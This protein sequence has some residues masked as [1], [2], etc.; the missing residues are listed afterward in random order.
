M[1]GCVEVSEAEAELE[2]ARRSLLVL[3]SVSTLPRKFKAMARAVG[4]AACVTSYEAATLRV[5]HRR[6]KARQRAVDAYRL[7]LYKEGQERLR[8]SPALRR[9]MM[10]T[11]EWAP[12]CEDETVAFGLDRRDRTFELRALRELPAPLQGSILRAGALHVLPRGRTRRTAYEHVRERCVGLCSLECGSDGCAGGGLEMQWPD[13]PEEFEEL[14]CEH[15]GAAQVRMRWRREGGGAGAATLV[16]GEPMAAGATQALGARATRNR[17]ACGTRCAAARRSATRPT[18]PGR[19]R[20]TTDSTDAA[21]DERE[22]T[23]GRAEDGRGRRGGGGDGPAP[24]GPDRCGGGSGSA[25]SV[26]RGGHAGSGP[27]AA[28]RRGHGGWCLRRRLPASPGAAK[29]RAPAAAR[30]RR[31]QPADRVPIV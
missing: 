21:I 29:R 16:A 4:H 9:A 13:S 8:T 7:R 30:W 15:C 26:G 31:R 3:L 20:A 14:R 18:M 1:E 22:R 10:C 28:R 19:L 27:G 6:N 25:R 24:G 12:R 17:T 11:H 2:S 23:G 5:R